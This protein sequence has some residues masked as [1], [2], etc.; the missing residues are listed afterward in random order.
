MARAYDSPPSSD[1]SEYRF[2]HQHRKSKFNLMLLPLYIA[3]I[4]THP[5]PP[6]RHKRSKEVVIQ[7]AITGHRS[8]HYKTPSSAAVAHEIHPDTILSRINGAR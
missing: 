5:M 7:E 6:I 3:S 4:Y 2:Y 8:G 1:W